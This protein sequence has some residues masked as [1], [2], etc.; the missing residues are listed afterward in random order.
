[1]R[2]LVGIDLGTTNSAMY[3]MDTE[4]VQ[5]SL[6]LFPI[7]QLTA[8]GKTDALPALPSF[9]YLSAQG[10][11]PKGSLKLSW[12][13]ENSL[14]VGKLAKV[15]G[16][17]VPT[18]LVQSAK[19]WL[20]NVAANRRDKILPI[21][22]ADIS[23]RLSPVEA[24]AN[25]LI[26]MRDAWN[27]SMAKGD[28]SA[29]L[30]EQE[31]MLTVPASFD[32]VARTLTVEAARL[33]GF[34]HV[35]LLEEPQ[36][37]FYS[38]IAQHE[39]EW[40][41]YFKA[42]DRIL[43]CDV[44]GGTT[45]F[46]LIEMHEKD[47]QLSFQR[48]AVGDHLLLGGDNMDAALAHDIENKMRSKGYP[49]LDSTQ[50]LQ[51]LA[52]ARE[53]KEELLGSGSADSYSVVIQGTGSSVVK[54]SLALTIEKKDVENLILNGFFGVYSLSEALQLRKSRGFRTM[55]LPYEDEPSITKH[56][57]HFLQQAQCLGEQG[58]VDYILFN[59]GTMKPAPFQA[60]LLDS[61]KSWFPNKDPQV[62]SSVNLDLAV[63][64]GAA[65]YGKVRRGMGVAIRGGLPRTYYLEVEVKNAAGQAQMQALTLL[66]RGSEEG[67]MLQ[68]PQT[69]SLRANT[70]VVFHLLTSHVRL[71]DQAGD[72]IAIDENEMQRLPPIQTI[73]RFG[74]K[75][76]ANEADQ[77]IPV[78]MG[79]KLTAV[80]TVELW[81]ESQRTEHRWNLEFQ[82]R[83]AAGQDNS[84]I[85]TEK[86]QKDETYAAGYLEQAK[87]SIEALFNG[88]IKP[89]QIMEKLESQLNLPRH[90]WPP[91]VLRG[92]WDQ[93]LKC[94][95]LR[96][97]SAEHEMRWWNL[98][99]FLLRPG[100]GYPLDDFRIKEL[101]KIILGD[102]KAIKNPDCQ[103]QLW[104]CFRRIA[105]GLNKGQQMQIAGEM[106]A[107]LID[108]KTSRI[109]PKRKSESYAY[110]EKLRAS[111][112]L[113]RVEIPLKV[114]LGEAL[115]NKIVQGQ[116]EPFEF[117]SLGRIGARHLFYGSAAQVVPKDMCAKWVEKLLKGIVVENE[118]G[119]FLLSQLARKT[120]HRE[121]N[122]PDSLLEALIAKY[123]SLK[124]Y[125]FEERNL[126]AKEK[127]QVFGES[128]PAGLVL[129]I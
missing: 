35:T 97:Q 93:L 9:C 99:G 108:K 113:E 78:K 54:G 48:M 120:D 59:G 27:A 125:L 10:E 1:M 17:R 92:L 66:P 75:Q 18:R 34:R 7:M 2:Y 52:E 14:F 102:L 77:I 53:A 114:R 71:H 40:Q 81:L 30:E 32:E 3:F 112:A 90:E 13:A 128:L 12:K 94:A 95:T 89:S 20:C 74:R 33:A 64:R 22:A 61:L 29:E 116:A 4:K 103:I 82:L 49:P 111:A 72:L 60:A 101:W 6:Q 62:L 96:K 80:G 46:S 43:V 21:E 68:S 55:G 83:S 121:L 5:N 100:Y 65:Y 15:Q 23:Q 109:E 122:L 67:C 115:V 44:G 76:A 26:H 58:G 127:E 50:W 31:V 24:S 51:L 56:L 107:D 123:P 117:W 39:Q 73:L 88:S 124:A 37:A 129:E 19:S 69:F 106:M 87:L 85:A 42:G 70:P 25:Y 98:A 28:A 118:Q 8:L 105:G 104:I 57:A 47:G 84:M 126:S 41:D 63:A 16:A 36:A 91:S 86:K 79:I 38:W 45:D 119:L 11:W 110:S